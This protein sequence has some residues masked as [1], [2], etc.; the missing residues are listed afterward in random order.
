[1]TNDEG[2]MTNSSWFF[3]NPLHTQDRT[4]N[5]RH[6]NPEGALRRPHLHGPFT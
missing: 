1:M 6:G 4:F 2:R 3:K 5:P